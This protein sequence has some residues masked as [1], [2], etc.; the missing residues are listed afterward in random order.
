MPN[1][2]FRAR[3]DSECDLAPENPSNPERVLS[4]TQLLVIIFLPV[5]CLNIGTILALAYFV[6]AFDGPRPCKAINE[7]RPVAL[8]DEG[9]TP[10]PT[11]AL[12]P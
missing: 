1:A 10:P 8:H 6:G 11:S 9:P 12:R 5:A 7:S 2:Q 4:V 3:V